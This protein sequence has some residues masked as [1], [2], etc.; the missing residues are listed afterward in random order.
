MNSE[1]RERPAT[2]G[3]R[4]AVEPAPKHYYSPS[5]RGFYVEDVTPVIPPDAAAI[6]EAE[7]GELLA[8]QTAGGAIVFAD[9]RPSLSRPTAARTRN[10]EIAAQIAALEATVTPRTLQEAVTNSTA[11]GLGPDKSLTAAAYV[12]S[13]RAQVTALRAR[14]KP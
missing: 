11:V 2:P 14:L 13:I 8:G 5:T 1:Q 6:T 3:D 7:Y 9:G 12:A 4:E 10:A